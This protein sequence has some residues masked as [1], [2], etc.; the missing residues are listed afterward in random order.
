MDQQLLC[1][2]IILDVHKIVHNE[3]GYPDGNLNP[4][5]KFNL[6]IPSVFTFSQNPM[7]LNS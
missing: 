2:E 7:L 1:S 4:T 6:E 3:V 5:G